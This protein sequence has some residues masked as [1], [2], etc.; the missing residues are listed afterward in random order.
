MATIEVRKKYYLIVFYSSIKNP[1]RVKLVFK[2]S[3]YTKRQVMDIKRELET[4]YKTGDYDPWANKVDITPTAGPVYMTEV[5][6]KYIAYKSREDWGYKTTKDYGRILRMFC[7]HH[8]GKLLSS[9]SASD[10]NDFIN[11]DGL[12]YDTCESYQR[13][14]RTFAKWLY[15][16][17]YHTGIKRVDIKVFRRQKQRETMRYLSMSEQDRLIKGIYRKVR[18]DIASGLQSYDNNSMWLIDF[19]R[20][21]RYS[22]MRLSETINLE[23]ADINTDTWE[24]TIGNEHFRTKLNEKQ[25]L[26]IG[27]V[28]Q[29]T[30]I[31]RR[32]LLKPGPRLFAHRDPKR[33]SKM[34]LKYR[35][36]A[37]PNRPDVTVHTLRHSCCI[38]LI[39]AGVDIYR[40]QRW[41]RHK[42]IKTTLRYADIAQVDLS[43]DVGRAFRD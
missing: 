19:I 42:S 23:H 17:D 4:R 26:P 25:V 33:A 39:K 37:L 35:Q 2:K 34:F 10:M 1:T 32:W 28:P 22:G 40:V 7:S 36:I 5:V 41:M 11:R 14:F 12:A 6:D 30:R 20:W 24:V 29:L 16:N 21:Q 9:L 43:R 18:D 27:G 31:A 13:I 38:D 3:E 8:K 15:D